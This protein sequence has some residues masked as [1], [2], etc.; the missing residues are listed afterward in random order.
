MSK[1]QGFWN[2]LFW[3]KLFGNNKQGGCCNMEIIEESADC[4]GNL[5]NAGA[6]ENCCGT[7]GSSVKKSASTPKHPRCCE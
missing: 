5:K 7:P 2:K 1:K 4:C 3:N 6:S